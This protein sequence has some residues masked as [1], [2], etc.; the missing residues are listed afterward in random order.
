MG[1]HCRRDT[2]SAS[3]AACQCLTCMLMMTEILSCKL[4][5]TQDNS[6]SKKCCSMQLDL[7]YNIVLRLNNVHRMMP[8]IILCRKSS[9]LISK[10]ESDSAIGHAFYVA[11]ELYDRNC[12]IIVL[13]SSLFRLFWCRNWKPKETILCTCATFPKLFRKFLSCCGFRRWDIL[14]LVMDVFQGWY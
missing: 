13:I 1:H 8:Y 2:V 6:N 5:Q 12:R 3:T 10:D 7:A 11:I 9:K 4:T 14:H